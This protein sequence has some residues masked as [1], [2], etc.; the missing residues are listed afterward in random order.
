MRN[1][2]HRSNSTPCAPSAF[3][4][5]APRLHDLDKVVENAIGNVLVENSLVAEFLQIEL[6]ALKLDTL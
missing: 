5:G 3:E 6:Q 2:D 1:R 4:R